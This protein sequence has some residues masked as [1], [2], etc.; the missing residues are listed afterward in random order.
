MPV[1]VPTPAQHAAI[2]YLHDMVVI[3]RPGS[4]KTRVISEKIRRVL[5]NLAVFQGV[6][7]ISYTNK[8]SDELERRC[9]ADAFDIK[10]SLFGTIDVFCLREIIRPF[11]R[12]V[13]PAL[14]ELKVTKLADLPE[15]V[16]ALRPGL[17]LDEARA[18][19]IEQFIPFFSAALSHGHVPLEAVAVLAWH[20]LHQ[21]PACQRYLKARYGAVYIDEYQDSD[22]F[23]HQL[24][25]K[26]RG[27]GLTAIAVGDVD[28]SI[29]EFTN[30]HARY[31]QELTKEGSGFQAFHITVNWRSHPSISDFALRLLN[32]NHPVQPTDDP[33]VFLKSVSGDQKAIAEWL[34]TAI[35]SFMQHYKVVAPERV[36]VLCRSEDSARLIGR[37]LGFTNHVFER[38]PFQRSSSTEARTFES[39]LELRFDSS[40]S[41]QALIDTWG[42]LGLSTAGKRALRQLI[43]RCRTCTEIDLPAAV[44]EASARLT[45]QPLS[46]AGVQELQ[47]VCADADLLRRLCPPIGGAVQIMTLH[48]SKG[49]EFD[50]VFHADLY[51]YILPRRVIIKG[52]FDV[53]FENELQCLNLHYV[54]I[55]RAI[56]ACVLLTSTS[57][58]NAHGQEKKG[59][60]SQFLGRNGT[61]AAPIQW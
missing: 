35:P 20:I 57:R 21:S 28:Q 56:H 34:R 3:A 17:A 29:F 15:A 49:L 46:E 33:R 14:T 39:L 41:A 5:P 43:L 11:S 26:L 18:Q 45:G 16:S 1:F 8:A 19:H 58:I 38:T 25:L 55:T 24:F 37:H 47:E 7:A 2:E 42:G 60:P 54:G 51:D 36:A 32:P 59:A 22:Y 53:I 44:A 30:K 4:G 6:I 10:Q 50:L 40:L 9:K 13:M 27:L 12:H 48:K 31:L 61:S 52:N 23:Q